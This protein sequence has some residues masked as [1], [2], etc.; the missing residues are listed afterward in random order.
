[1]LPHVP[2][3]LL[4]CC[5]LVASVGIW[6]LASA[7]RPPHSPV[8][9][10]QV[11][12]FGVG[13]VALVGVALIDYRLIQRLAVPIYV[14]NILT[15]IALK[16]VGHK[17]KGAESWL[18]LGPLRMQPAEFMKIG[19]LLMLAKYFHD[20]YRPN[21]DSYGFIRLIPPVLLAIVPIVIVLVEPELGTALMMLFTAMTVFLFARVRWW[22]VTV[23]GVGVLLGA[24]V[25]W[26]DWVRE[27]PEPRVTVIRHFMKRHQT[28]RIS[29]WLDPTTDLRGTNYHSMQSKIAVGSGGLGGKGWMKGTQTGLFFLPEQHTD[30]IFSVWA[31]EH[32]FLAC[33]GL[34]V[35][36]GGIFVTALGVAFN[37]RDRFGAFLA[38]GVAAMIFWQVFENIGM[39]TG[40]TP[41]T[42]ITLPLMS[43]GGSSVV[44]MLIGIGLLVNVSMRRHI[45]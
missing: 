20:D 15:L 13:L 4:V 14:F 44:S 42:G 11:A 43:Y 5:F 32:G 35:L 18:V 30:F 36:Y 45:F 38:V 23:I 10:T 27:Q 26:N 33:L 17:A 39:V 34:L 25:M 8:W 22:V 3:A 40:L 29:A 37:A 31:E 1:M 16:F 28:Q 19:M 21:Q 12:Y 2:W 6:N 41:V 9:L 24:L 7:S